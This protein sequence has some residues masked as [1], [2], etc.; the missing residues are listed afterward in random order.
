MSKSNTFENDLLKLIF[1]AVAIANL[2]D[3]AAGA[4]LTALY[5]ALHTADPGEAGGQ[6]TSEIAYTGYARKSVTRSGIG[7]TVTANSVS[8][9]ADIEFPEMAGGA[10]GTATHASVGTDLAG[11]GKI[12]YRGAL[13]PTILCALGVTPRI[14]TT[15]TITEE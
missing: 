3:N 2:A 11:V 14:R 6:S 9:A 15:S 4:P 13:T 12:L 7:W 8:P 5:V 1:N 10:G